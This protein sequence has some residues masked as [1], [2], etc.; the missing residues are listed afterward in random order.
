[1]PELTKMWAKH[2]DSLV[3]AF[4]LVF[5]FVFF[6]FIFQMNRNR[7]LVHQLLVKHFQIEANESH[8]INLD[9]A[10]SI[11]P[12]G[13]FTELMKWIKYAGHSGNF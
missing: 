8:R 6:F 5:L 10:A 1:M 7:F 11:S 9:F 2:Y 12:N 3:H 13:K 4:K